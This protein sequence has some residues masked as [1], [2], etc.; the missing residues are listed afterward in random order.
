VAVVPAHR[1][2]VSAE[3]DYDA[4]PG[5]LS[6]LLG[7]LFDPVTFLQQHPLLLLSFVFGI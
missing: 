6:R 2:R 3:I 5:S 1:N 4:D 7:E